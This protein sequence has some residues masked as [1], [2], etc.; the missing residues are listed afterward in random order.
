MTKALGRIDWSKDASQIRNLIRGT[1][2][3]PGAFSIY[4]G[5]VFKIMCAELSEPDVKN[6]KWGSILKVEK[7]SIIVS[8]GTGN[9]RILELQ[10]ENEKRMS[11][12]AYLR[13]HGITEGAVL[14]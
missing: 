14:E 8:C 3:W 9:L 2:P 6:E 7:D 10:F 5:K 13:G 12:E 1:Y 4:C 11:V